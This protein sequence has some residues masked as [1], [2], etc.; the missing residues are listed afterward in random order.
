MYQYRT[1]RAAI[2]NE[3][4]IRET[5]DQCGWSA[6]KLWNVGRYYI[7][8][9]WDAT[10]EIPSENQ[11]KHALKD[12]DRYK[13]L[14]SQSSQRVLSELA[15]AFRAWYRTDDE[16]ANPPG[17]RKRRY[18]DDAGNLVHEEHPRSTV[19]WKR[20]AIQH[21][22][23]QN[24]LRLSKGQNFKTSWRDFLWVDY[25]TAPDIT[26]ENIQQ[27]RAV[28]RSAADSWELHIVCRHEREQP[29]PPGDGTAGVD[30]GI[31]NAAAVSFSTGHHA[32]FPGN[33]LKED[34]YYF[35]KEIAACGRATSNRASRLHRLR[36]K[37]RRHFFHALSKEIVDQCVEQ[38]VG[39][40]VVGDLEGVR[41]KGTT[42]E[43]KDWGPA[44]NL[45]LH[46]WGFA[47]LTKLLTYKAKA[48]G[49]TVDLVSE[50]GT[51]Q[52]CCQCGGTDGTARV[53][54]GLLVCR[55]CDVALNADVNGAENIR[56]QR[57]SE[58]A[59]SV[60]RST[61]CVA[62]PTVYLYDRTCGF[63]PQATVVD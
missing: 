39:T 55:D 33:A 9:E 41:N 1:H 25:A 45:A 12:H 42:D 60:D 56:Q 52:T 50:Q 51:S 44:G 62:Q 26:V 35:R 8:Q 15:E 59:A 48:Q 32:L 57:N 20:D 29:E 19:T 2:R 24:H 18:Y 54:R 53:E 3:E 16:R 30:L 28:Y 17:Y 58:S 43:P 36:S 47:R 38:G 4:Q 7:Q 31:C 23:S 40:L 63:Q 34:E 14:H 61:G 21:H 11:L 22:P 46:E 13:D 5:L 49:I 27:V 10:G 6:A 37:R